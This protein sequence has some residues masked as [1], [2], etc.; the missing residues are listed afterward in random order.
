MK[1]I[2]ALLAIIIACVVAQTV[3]QPVPSTNP[4][5]T[6]LFPTS[7]LT[8]VPATSPTAV[9]PVAPTPLCRKRKVMGTD[10]ERLAWAMFGTTLFLGVTSLVLASLLAWKWTELNRER[11]GKSVVMAS[12]ARPHHDHSNMH[13]NVHPAVVMG[14]LGSSRR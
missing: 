2:F 10:A 6:L 5:G 11:H 14:G 3:L 8:D 4:P 1:F 7:S 12:N 13:Q 9:A